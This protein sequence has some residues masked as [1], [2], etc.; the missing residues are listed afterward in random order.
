MPSRSLQNHKCLRHWLFVA[1]CVLASAHLSAYP[2]TP[3]KNPEVLWR[4]RVEPLLDKA[5]LKCH[6]GVRQQGGLDLRSLETILRGGGRGSA[7]VPGQPSAS[8]IVQYVSPKSDNPMPPDSKKRLNTDEI[9]LLKEWIASLPAPKTKL[10]PGMPTSSTWLAEYMESYRG[11]LPKQGAPPAN[12]EPSAAIDW[13]LQAD[14]KRDKI[15]PARVCDDATFVRRLYL[16]MVGRIPS[17][18]ERK[19]FISNPAPNK[20]RSLLTTLLESNEYPRRMRELFDTVLMGRPSEQNARD[21][22][23]KGWNRFLEDSFRVNRPWNETVKSIL[24]ARSLETQNR[25]ADWF[26]AEKENRH[27]AMAEAVAPIAFGVQIQCAQCHN[28]P[29]VWE[30]EQRHYWGLVTTFN[31]SKNVATEKGLGVGES[32]VGGFINFANLKKES[33]PAVMVFLNGKSVPEHIPSANEKE[34]DSPDLYTVPPAKEG[35]KPQFPAVPKFSRREAFAEAVTHDNPRLARAFVN[36]MWAYL[37]GRGIV[38]PVDQI[39]SRHRPS[40]PEL[41]DWLTA[42]FEKS[43]YDIKRLIQS[44]VLSRAYQLDS[45]LTSKTPP[46]PDTFARSIEKPLSAEQILHSLIVATEN[47]VE[48]AAL[49]PIERNFVTTFPDVMPENY[50]PSLQQALFYSN[51]PILNGLL[52]SAPNNLTSKLML[53]KSAEVQIKEAFLTVLGRQPD[54]TELQQCKL[55]LSTQSSEKGIRNLI[56]AL[57]TSAEFQVNH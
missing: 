55:L 53:Q 7:I 1:Y 51:S 8:R 39:D 40:H 30:I 37:M 24:L 15:V 52:K 49:A 18:E 54:A 32:A 46:R 10:V 5:C 45:A 38:Q 6:A 20:R 33:Q 34:V 3:L 21:R 11:A 27:Q 25:G 48:D 57:L 22:A 17:R 35:Q 19:Q 13:M 56:W 14:W 41:L 9:A 12:L 16:D 44:I 4:E 23:E 26:L 31:R 42:D 43:G 47:R 2:Q 36:R 28:H 29:L 50:N